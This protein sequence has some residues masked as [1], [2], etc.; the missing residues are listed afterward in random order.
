MHNHPPP[1]IHPAIQGMRVRSD[2]PQLISQMVSKYL[3][4]DCSVLMG[5]NIAKDIGAEE[6]GLHWGGTGVALGL[7]W[8]CTGLH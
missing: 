3:N 2:G 7:H 4:I 6:V 1:P 5:A 8:G